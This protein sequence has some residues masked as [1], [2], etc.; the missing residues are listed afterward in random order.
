MVT[1]S[2][3]SAGS[4]RPSSPRRR[5]SPGTP[6]PARR[7]VLYRIGPGATPAVGDLVASRPPDALAAFLAERGYVGRGAL[8]LKP[9]ATVTG[10][11]VCRI[12]LSVSIGST[13]IVEARVRDRLGA[14]CR[15]GRAASGSPRAKCSSSARRP[16]PPRRWVHRPDRPQRRHRPGNADLA[17]A[18]HCQ[19]R[20]PRR[21]TV[22]R[23]VKVHRP[24]RHRETRQTSM[25]NTIMTIAG[26]DWRP[27]NS[28]R[29]RAEGQPACQSSEYGC[30]QILRKLGKSA[31]GG[32]SFPEVTS[33]KNDH[34]IHKKAYSVQDGGQ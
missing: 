24:R 32:K 21:Q 28:S 3:A 11:R 30:K 18:R 16:G 1:T 19:H 23:A 2:R 9:I 20:R 4:L 10:Q 6:R 15:T 17:P 26:T 14:T 5:A 7:P 27:F 25:H 33:Q 29:S 34:T 12:G 22:V 31:H 8:L 13:V